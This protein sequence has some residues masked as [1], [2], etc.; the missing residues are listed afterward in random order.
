MVKT[1]KPLTT[2]VLSNGE[3]ISILFFVA[4]LSIILVYMDGYI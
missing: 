3:C 1:L 4:D 2:F